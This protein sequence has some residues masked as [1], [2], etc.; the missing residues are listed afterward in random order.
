M[1]LVILV[2]GG[3][4]S[5]LVAHLAKEQGVSQHPLFMDYGQRARDRELEACRRAM[6]A[7]G[8]PPP[9]VAD[10]SGYGR[11]IRSGLTDPT[12]RVLEDAFTPGRNLLFLLTAAAHACKLGAEGVSI[13]LLHEDTH[14]FPDQT[15]AFL[16]EAESLISRVM[17]RHVSVIAPLA[18]FHKR[19]VVRL[20]RV[21]GV[22][23]TYSCHLGGEE[24]CGACIACNE[25]KFEED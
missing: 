7:L 20:A 1:S 18:E 3:L 4:D 19:D 15:R 8:L 5:T 2:S 12:L 25:F 17:G 24:P 22:S 13:G 10:L 11:L 16:T 14:L 9:T 21:K 23:G 6:A